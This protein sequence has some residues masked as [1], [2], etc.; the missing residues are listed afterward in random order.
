LVV[1]AQIVF[2]L[3]TSRARASGTADTEPL[4][5]YDRFGYSYTGLTESVAIPDEPLYTGALGYTFI[6]GARLGQWKT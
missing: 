1:A 6:F 3:I 2:V 4:L 5:G